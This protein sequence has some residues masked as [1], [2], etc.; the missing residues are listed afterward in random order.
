MPSN[1]HSR[2]DHQTDRRHLGASG[3]PAPLLLVLAAATACGG[4]TDNDV[5]T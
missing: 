1:S 2:T 5:G 3:M 4:G